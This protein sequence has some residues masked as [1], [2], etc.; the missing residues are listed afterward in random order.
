VQSLLSSHISGLEKVWR[1]RSSLGIWFFLAYI[2]LFNTERNANT[3]PVVSSK[4][5]KTRTLDQSNN[6]RRRRRRRGRD[7]SVLLLSWWNSVWHNMRDC[8]GGDS[9]QRQQ[10]QS[11]NQKWIEKP[12][13][14][15]SRTLHW[16]H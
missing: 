11:R 5:I 14:R 15:L 16:Q 13:R 7:D 3:K 1:S 6:W 4:K 10:H 2:V 12:P 8:V 9:K